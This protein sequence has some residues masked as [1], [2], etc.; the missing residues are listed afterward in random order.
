MFVVVFVRL[1][2]ILHRLGDRYLV[3]FTMI[4]QARQTSLFLS[5][6]DLAFPP[7]LHCF[8]QRQDTPRVVSN[9]PHGENSHWERLVS[10]CCVLV[11]V[12]AGHVLYFLMSSMQIAVLPPRREGEA[13]QD[14]LVGPSLG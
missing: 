6:V 8:F 7:N 9:F 4:I 5:S 3:Q 1:S 2:A 13:F 14:S 10:S 12:T 11:R